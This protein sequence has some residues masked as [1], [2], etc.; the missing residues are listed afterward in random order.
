[1]RKGDGTDN[2]LHSRESVTQ[3]DPL[4]VVSY[5]IGILLMIK[6]LN[7]MYPAITQ[8][9]YAANSGALGMFDNLERYFNLLK[10]NGPDQGYYPNPTK[11]ILAVHPKKPGEGRLFGWCHLFKVCVGVSYLGVN[12]GDGV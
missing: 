4:G 12:I 11:S 6:H 5:M 2:I 10:L 1:M 8:P 3:G 7:S 9:W